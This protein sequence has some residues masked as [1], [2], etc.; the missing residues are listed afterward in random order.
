MG[1][2]KSCILVAALLT[3]AA[4]SGVTTYYVHEPSGKWERVECQRSGDRTILFTDTTY[5]CEER[6][7]SAHEANAYR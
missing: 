4:C 3:L 1:V 5:H 2:L 6:H 7:V